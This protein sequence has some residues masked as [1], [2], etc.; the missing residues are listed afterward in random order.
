[1][2]PD[3]ERHN[4]VLEAEAPALFASLSPLGRRIAFPRGIPF[5]ADQARQTRYN[6]TIGQVTDGR[7]SPL[8]LPSMDAW[9]GDLDR[10]VSLLYSPQPGHAEI[11]RLWFDWQLAQAGRATFAHAGLPV[12]THGL[13]H[14]LAV[15]ADLFTSPETTV[16]LP[17]P[18]WENYDLVFTGWSG[19]KLATWDFYDADGAFAP[20]NLAEALQRIE[21]RLVAVLNF[22]AN[23]TGYS[24]TPA[25][26]R[27]V[28]EGVLAARRGPTVVVVD[29]A[30]QG[31]VHVPGVVRHSLFWDLAERAD[32]ATHVV[33]KVDGATKELLFF[34]S[35]LGFLTA[36][37]TGAA[38]ASF[39]DKVNAA[40]RG[41]VGSPPG[42]SQAL[43]LPLLRDADATRREVAAQLAPIT[44][45]FEALR[46]ALAATPDPLW[47]PFAF[48]SAYFAM[49]GM[50]DGVDCEAVRRALLADDVGT[51]A[52]PEAN[53]LRIA[54]CS[55][56]AEDIPELVARIDRALR[57]FKR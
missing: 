51:I 40:I 23:P 54:Y 18:S 17:N 37:V 39:F 1:M 5:Q 27:Q 11:R 8:P 24:P 48:N 33:L 13:T 34:P 45:R 16:L 57:D 6:A 22:P 55:M 21:G 49:I 2:M 31:V 15:I 41:T 30:Y 20:Q 44:G 3:A 38:E 9:L 47:R 28:I 36:S 14:G 29:D 53:A 46:D 7:G 12:A 26:A 25:E 43:M 35:R 52:L 10:K 42:P 50:P 56:A 19:A 32:P 4:R